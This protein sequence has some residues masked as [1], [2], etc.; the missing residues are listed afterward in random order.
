MFQRILAAAALALAAAAGAGLSSRA[1]AAPASPPPRADSISIPSSV[2]EE[3]LE[4]MAALIAAAQERG[5]VGEAARQ[6]GDAL[7]PHFAREERIALPPLGLLRPLSEGVVPPDAGAVLP[8]TDTLLAELPRMME[9]HRRIAAALSHF[10][11]VALNEGVHRHEMLVV[12]L[13]R[14]ARTEEE[15]LYPAAV[16]VGDLV[17]ARQAGWQRK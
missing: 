16:L 11:A 2:Q 1:P 9:E 4:L 6:L 3:H 13:R 5:P 12:S 15:V 17:R 10:E 14:H 8:L 7:Q